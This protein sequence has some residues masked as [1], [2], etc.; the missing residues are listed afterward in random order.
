MELCFKT[1]SSRLCA[2]PSCKY[3]AVPYI[4]NREGVSSPSKGAPSRI[5]EACVRVPISWRMG[6]SK[7]ESVYRG[8]G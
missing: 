5:P 1:A 2:D 8:G 7:D 3:G 6:E 4:P